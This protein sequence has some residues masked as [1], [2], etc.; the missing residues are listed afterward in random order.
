MHRPVRFVWILTDLL[1]FLLNVQNIIFL[2]NEGEKEFC[3][4][5]VDFDNKDSFVWN[6]TSLFFFFCLPGI[7]A[8]A[9]ISPGCKNSADLWTAW[10]FGVWTTWDNW[11]VRLSNCLCIFCS[12]SSVLSPFLWWSLDLDRECFLFLL[13]LIVK[14]FL[15]FLSFNEMCEVKHNKTIWRVEGAGVYPQ[16]RERQCRVRYTLNVVKLGMLSI[17]TSFHHLRTRRFI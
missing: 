11:L 14:P 15:L 5:R 8:S 10:G 2:P 13:F 12:F 3:R 4:I 17:T 7:W 1:P 6:V 9:V 16:A